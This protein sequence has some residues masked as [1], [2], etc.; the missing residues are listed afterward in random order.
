MPYGIAEVRRFSFDW[1][2]SHLDRLASGTPDERYAALDAIADTR[3]RWTAGVFHALLPDP[4]SAF[5][6]EYLLHA[7][8]V[9][10]PR[11]G[12]GKGQPLVDGGAA[13]HAGAARIFLSSL[14]P[15]LLGGAAVA[16]RS[17]APPSADARAL[18][19]CLYRPELA[20][21]RGLAAIES[22]D[23]M[24]PDGWERHDLLIRY[25]LVAGLDACSDPETVRMLTD[26]VADSCERSPGIVGRCLRAIHRKAPANAIECASKI[27]DEHT[28]FFRRQA[29][30]DFL[31]E[32]VPEWLV[33]QTNRGGGCPIAARALARWRPDYALGIF[34]DWLARNEKEFR[35]AGTDALFELI[36]ME[37][38]APTAK[39]ARRLDACR[40]LSQAVL[41]DKYCYVRPSALANLAELGWPDWEEWARLMLSD[42]ETLPRFEAIGLLDDKDG[43]VECRQAVA[44]LCDP[45]RTTRE[46]TLALAR[47]RAWDPKQVAAALRGLDFSSE[48]AA[49]AVEMLAH[50]GHPEGYE[51]VR[52]LLRRCARARCG[53]RP[54]RPAPSSPRTAR[55]GCGSWPAGSTTRSPASAA[56]RWKC[57]KRTAPPPTCRGS[58]RGSATRNPRSGRRRSAPRAGWRRSGRRN[59]PQTC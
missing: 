39:S 1:L 22:C 18:Y 26:H 29:A 34:R 53:S 14:P 3:W 45:E 4:T 16:P 57:S 49:H 38:L 37:Q 21:V 43:A 35:N 19:Y 44:L 5:M 59:W 30:A 41:D 10:D 13:P 32:I 58:C 20:L 28:T 31:A 51:A 47:R 2:Q 52:H 6:T 55:P 24:L 54:L 48:A 11:L 15:R 7:L 8:F 27:F 40:E 42:G 25:Q 36:A 12:V 9:I 56:S 50:F 17:F 46:R 33:G 23:E